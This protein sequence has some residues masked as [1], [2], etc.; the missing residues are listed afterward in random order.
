MQHEEKCKGLNS[1]TCPKCMTVF[2]SKSAKYKHKM[3]NY[4]KAKSI[5][6]Y[7]N[8]N[9]QNV[10]Q[11]SKVN[12]SFNTTNNITN[13][14]TINNNTTNKIY[15][16]IVND[17]GK[18]RKDYITTDA[19][20]KVLV[21]RNIIPDYIDLKHFN[22]KFPEN[23][24][25]KIENNVWRAWYLSCR[26]WEEINGIIEPF[27]DIKYAESNNGIDW[28]P[29]NIT[30]I[31][32]S[33]D[34]GGIAQASVVKEKDLYHMWFSARKKT[35]YRNNPKNSYKIFHATSQDGYK[36]AINKKPDLDISLQG[37]DSIMVEYP[38]VFKYLDEYY[39]F[40]NGN[41]FGKEGIGYAI[42][43][44]SLSVR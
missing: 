24:N 2:S 11:H 30:C 6:E 22:E 8:P 19:I 23:N 15:N 38:Y 18:E 10:I 31:P 40:Y 5:S 27:Y 3:R 36:W 41:G 1:L 43:K 42:K 14:N 9:L 32:L 7:Q 34:Y 37:W 17:Y 28:Q 4:C 21:N 16:I 39:M 12:N 33:E 35:D 25:I 20:I 26:R 29:T 13:N 44:N